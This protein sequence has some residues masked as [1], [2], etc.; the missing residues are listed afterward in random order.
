MKTDRS[1]RYGKGG[2]EWKKKGG[3]RKKHVFFFGFVIFNQNQK[4]ERNLKSA[5]FSHTTRYLLHRFSRYCQFS[6]KM[7][8]QAPLTHPNSSSTFRNFTIRSQ[9]FSMGF[10]SSL[11]E[12]HFNSV[13]FQPTLR[14]I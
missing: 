1:K 9:T 13:I 7:E 11:R 10:K 12:G 8:C 2:T 6:T 3:D 14:H 4:S 5:S